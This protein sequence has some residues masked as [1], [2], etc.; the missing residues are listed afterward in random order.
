MRLPLCAAMLAGCTGPATLAIDGDRPI[1]ESMNEM[2]VGVADTAATGGTFGRLYPFTTKLVLPQT[3]RVEPGGAS[4]AYAWVRADRSGVPI[5]E[6]GAALDFGGQTTLT[7]NTCADGPATLP[8]T[9]GKPVGPANALLAASIGDGGVIVLAIG[10]TAASQITA[11]DGALVAADGPALPTGNPVAV[12]AID[13]D[14]DCDD[15]AIVLTDGAPPEI[16]I[17]DHETFRDSG[18]AL[19]T[20]PATAIATADVDGDGDMDVVL[21]AGSALE[22]WRNQGNGQ[23]VLDTSGALV[24]GGKVSSVT[25][26]ALGDVDG[27]G[28]PD[29]VVGQG[30]GALVAWLGGQ[31]G[32]TFNAAVVP[33]LPL[34]V[35]RLT[36]ADVTGDFQ[37]DLSIAV[38]G[39]AMHLLIDRDG[40]L[41]D[42]TY[43]FLPAPIPTAHAIA[44]GGWNNVCLPDAVVASDLGTP[45]WTGVASGMFA[46]EASIAPPSTDVVMT[47]L[48]SSGLLSALF[49]T[50]NGVQWLAR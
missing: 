44:I 12:A 28:Y 22:L 42:Q 47:D 48:D 39:S 3:L 19:G 17:R 2:C 49:A 25:A 46:A 13:V 50:A 23:F 32:F 40:R 15:D 36:L 7:L 4:A 29:L 16:W 11:R 1:P 20:T 35:E 33:A 14:G 30:S 45:T 10:A 5:A 26:L 6:T 41:E 21:G 8:H 34:A 9:V 43:D 31:S 38:N 27:D 24:A 18:S 37:P